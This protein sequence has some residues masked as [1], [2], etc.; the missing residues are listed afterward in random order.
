ML[1]NLRVN[2][3]ILHPNTPFL[4]PPGPVLSPVSSCKHHCHLS[5]QILVVVED[6]T[7]NLS[8]WPLAHRDYPLIDEGAL[9]VSEE[10]YGAPVSGFTPDGL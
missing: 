10:K 9:D 5:P 8:I 4:T 7:L 1:M 2:I 3:P 6:P